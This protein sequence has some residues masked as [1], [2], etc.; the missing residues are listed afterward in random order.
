MAQAIVAHRNPRATSGDTSARKRRWWWTWMV[1]DI[2]PVWSAADR[3]LWPPQ[4][5]PPTGKT[6]MILDSVWLDIQP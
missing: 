2:D 3:A 1:R 5:P 4:R 6:R